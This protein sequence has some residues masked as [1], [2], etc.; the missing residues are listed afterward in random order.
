MEA[1]IVSTDDKHPSDDFLRRFAAGTASREEGRQISAHLLRRCASCAKRLQELVRPSIPEEAYD[2]AFARLEAYSRRDAGTAG[3]PASPPA[4]ILLAELDEIPTLRQQFLVR[5]SRRYLSPDLARLLAERSFELRY[6]DPR[7]MLRAA[8]LAATLAERLQEAGAGDAAQLAD[9]RAL[10]ASQLGNALRI[11]GDLAGAE[12]AISTA[13][14]SMRRGAGDA[15]LRALVSTN[16]GSLRTFQCRY[17]AAIR[18]YDDAAAIYRNL[19]KRHELASVLV[20]QAVAS[21]YAGDPEGGLALLFEA[22]PKIEGER[23]PRLTLAACHAVV[24]CQL[25]AGHIEDASLKWIELRFLYEQ[26]GDP[27]MRLK[28]QW[29]EGR[30]MIAQGVIPAGIRLLEKTRAVY[31]DRGMAY[32]AAVIALHIAQGHLS[33]GHHD[34]ARSLIAEVAPVFRDLNVEKNILSAFVHLRRVAQGGPLRW[35][36]E[37]SITEDRSSQH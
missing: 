10:C 16:L 37:S 13:L 11:T 5:N 18:T 30:L 17:E 15:S 25:D 12:Q 27:L 22:I 8:Q 24:N 14:S 33:L 23:D 7:R 20:G 34:R 35:P 21:L 28:G 32:D 9:L 36:A 19:G 3:S 1:D 31:Q 26:I 6:Q 2:A 4:A 29:L